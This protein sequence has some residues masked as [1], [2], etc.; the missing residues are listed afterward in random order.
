MM[1]RA[2]PG[3]RLKLTPRRIGVGEPGAL[4]KAF[5]TW[6][7]PSG[8]GSGMEGLCAGKSVSSPDNR[9]QAAR[10]ESSCFQAEITCSTGA[11]ARPERIEQAIIMP[12]VIVPWIAS[13][14]PAPRISDCRVTRTK[15]L[16]PAM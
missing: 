8:L 15:R 4:A 12:G 1:P 13:K 7:M 11:R 5:S 2:S 10:L 16:A 3:A 6:S 14:A 9:A